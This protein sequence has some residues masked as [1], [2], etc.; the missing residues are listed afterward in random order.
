MLNWGIP[1]HRR[2]IGRSHSHGVHMQSA[3]TRNLISSLKTV[4]GN[5]CTNSKTN[6][7]KRN[8]EKYKNNNPVYS[9]QQTVMPLK[10]GGKKLL[11]YRGLV[12]E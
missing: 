9:A 5:S 3:C 4:S 11:F 10:Y 2:K 1:N 6:N 8:M 12:I 7:K